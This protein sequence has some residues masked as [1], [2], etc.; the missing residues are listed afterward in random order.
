M[1][2]IIE[3]SLTNFIFQLRNIISS[4]FAGQPNI[5]SSCR[6]LIW[7]K[8]YVEM[9]KLETQLKGACYDLDYTVKAV[10][11][12]HNSKDTFAS[13]KALLK[14]AFFYKQQIDYD[15]NVRYRVANRGNN[16]KRPA[17]QRFSGSF[18]IPSFISSH[19]PSSPSTSMMSSLARADSIPQPNSQSFN[20]KSP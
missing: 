6:T 17:V 13:I 3:L 2:C 4:Y 5:G 14:D 7:S 19:L 16:Q 8:K 12:I 15:N 10:K 11:S 20:S 1:K 18:D 9:K